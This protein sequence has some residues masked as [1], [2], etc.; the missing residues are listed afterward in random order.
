[1]LGQKTLKPE[2]SSAFD[3]QCSVFALIPNPPPLPTFCV[4]PWL[5]A[6]VLRDVPWDVWSTFYPL[7]GFAASREK[8]LLAVPNSC[9]TLRRQA[10]KAWD[11][12][13]CLT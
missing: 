3:V 8:L 7:S 12:N 11:A 10:A 13:G 5:R 2:L 1:M 4:G 6:T 9:L